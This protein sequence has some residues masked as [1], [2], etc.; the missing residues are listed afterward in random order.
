MYYMPVC[1]IL[2]NLWIL[3]THLKWW[4]KLYQTNLLHSKILTYF[5]YPIN[6]EYCLLYLV[7]YINDNNLTVDVEKEQIIII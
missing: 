2:L 3:K 5:L 1:M 7:M 6:V 4:S